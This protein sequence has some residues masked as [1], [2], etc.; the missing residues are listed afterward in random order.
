MKNIKFIKITSFA[1]LIFAIAC[2]KDEC[3]YDVDSN[4]VAPPGCK[5][6]NTLNLSSGID[7]SGNVLLPGAGVVDPF[8]KLIN[9]PPLTACSNV[10]TST[11]NGSAYVVNFNNFSSANWVNQ[12]NAGTICPIDLGT[13]MTFGCNNPSNSQGQAV[14]YIFERSFCVI[15]DTNVDFS[16]TFEGDDRIYFELINNSTNTILSTSSTYN[17]SSVASTWIASSLALAAGSYSIR[18]YLVN[19]SSVVLGFTLAGSI[20]TSNGEPAISNNVAGCCENNTI[21]VL[22]LKDQNCN[23]IFDGTDSV[24]NGYVFN[25]KNS[26]GSIIATKTTD[27]NGNIFFSGLADGTY[28]VTIVPQSGWNSST[29]TGGSTVITVANN[30]V[31]LIQFINCP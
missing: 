14:P 2:N 25:L 30:A 16:F 12:V 19:V 27:I 22:N 10:L 7:A 20:A 29:P 28:T 26:S 21:S 6:E 17:Y 5:L 24:A 8:W 4:L 15:K 11:I 31:R 9:N 18:S 1:L 13:T 23:G 3:Q